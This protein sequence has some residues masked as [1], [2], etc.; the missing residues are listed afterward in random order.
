MANSVSASRGA[1]LSGEKTVTTSGTAEALLATGNVL[2]RS[3]SIIAKSA[4]TNQVYVGG[5]D[6]ATTTNDGL[7]AG[8][9]LNINLGPAHTIHLD[10]IFLDVDTDGEGVDFYASM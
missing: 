6:V 2:Y 7:D 1:F 4:N 8:D 9:V 10:D 5:A 3:L